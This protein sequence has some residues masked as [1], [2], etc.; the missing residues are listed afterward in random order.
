MN[1]RQFLLKGGIYFTSS[2]LAKGIPILIA[3]F[4]VHLIS[5]NEFGLWAIYQVFIVFASAAVSFSLVSKINRDFYVYDKIE[6]SNTVKSSLVIS[7]VIGSIV[8]FSFFIL[9][10]YFH[11]FVGIPTSW[12]MLLG[13]IGIG[14]S[15]HQIVLNLLRN[16]GKEWIY[17]AFELGKVILYI[18]FIYLFVYVY[19]LGWKGMVLAWLFSTS[20]I[21]IISLLAIIRKGYFSGIYSFKKVSALLQFSY[22][23]VFNLVGGSVI[24]LSDR[25]FIK[26]YLGENY[27]AYFVIGYTLS[28]GMILFAESFNKVW[29]PWFYKNI[30]DTNSNKRSQIVKYTYGIAI[31]LAL[32]A[33]ISFVVANMAVLYLLPNEYLVSLEVLPYITFALFCNAISLLLLPYFITTSNTKIVGRTVVL[34]AIVNLLLNFYLIPILGIKGAGISTLF[35]FMLKLLIFI[36]YYSYN[37]VFP[38]PWFGKKRYCR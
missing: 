4:L 21:G 7:L 18:T 17:A 30:N 2:A 1:L 12:L 34:V 8:V 26:Q 16:E 35:S 33:L 14:H 27:V 32:V 20:L 37:S 31:I 9:S 15:S 19:S 38:M 24:S 36:F 6:I 29:T 28:M 3:P 22:P 5:S 11:Q 23:L 13:V 25:L 10:R